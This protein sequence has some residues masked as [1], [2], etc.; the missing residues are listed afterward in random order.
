MKLEAGKRYISKLGFI[1]TPLEKV[2]FKGNSFY[3][4][5]YSPMGGNLRTANWSEDGQFCRD[6]FWRFGTYDGPCTLVEEYCDPD[7]E[8]AQETANTR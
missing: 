7:G 8:D 2:E 6:T 5:D 1:T 4:G 3:Q